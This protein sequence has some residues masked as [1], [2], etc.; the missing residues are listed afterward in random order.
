MRKRCGGD[1]R[2][3]GGYVEVAKREEDR[4]GYII[5]FYSLCDGE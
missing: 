5:S 4:L 1:W 2:W 3:N